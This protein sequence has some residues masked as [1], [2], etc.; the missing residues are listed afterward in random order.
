M[1]PAYHRTEPEHRTEPAHRPGRGERHSYG[2]LLRFLRYLTNDTRAQ[3]QIE[4]AVCVGTISL[5]AA[6]A[7]PAIADSISTVLLNT[8]AVLSGA[9][10]NAAASAGSNGGNG[11][12]N[13]TG[14]GGKKGN[15]GNPTPGAFKG[16]SPCAP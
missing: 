9:P 15:C 7:I 8:E 10:V 14:S 11:G 1:L 13:N 12:S 16:K 3:D 5:V 6:F 2:R 4:Y